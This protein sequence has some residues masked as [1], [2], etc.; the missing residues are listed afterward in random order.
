MKK[1]ILI[2]IVLIIL[3]AI[4]GTTY[5]LFFHKTEL[6]TEY[7]TIEGGS[8]NSSELPLTEGAPDLI[9]GLQLNKTVIT[10]GANMINFSSATLL[11]QAM[12]GIN[13]VKGYI[14]VPLESVFDKVSNL[15]HYTV[16]LSLSQKLEKDF[17][18]D[19]VVKAEDGEISK[20]YST[21]ISTIKAGTGALQISL[22]WDLDDDLDLHVFEPDGDEVYFGAPVSFPQDLDLNKFYFDRN[23]WVVKKYNPDN[24]EEY[25][26]SFLSKMKLK[27]QL[28]KLFNI[29]MK[30]ETS[31]YMKEKE[32]AYCGELD[33]DSNPACH[34]DGIRNENIFYVKPEPGTYTVKVDLF[35]R[36]KSILDVNGA[37]YAVTVKYGNKDMKLDSGHNNLVGQIPNSMKKNSNNRNGLIEICTFTIPGEVKKIEKKQEVDKDMSVYFDKMFD[38]LR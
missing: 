19:L 31:L 14:D 32:I 16:L 30:K 25:T 17:H 21:D 1:K 5:F 15:Y 8:Y 24:D 4:I 2:P 27:Y 36:C 34:I 13:G 35:S 29:N 3:V 38:L 37:K 11:K 18:L 23:V 7:L 28:F 12:V 33:I 6:E 20:P 22:S 26:Q 10:G 9:T